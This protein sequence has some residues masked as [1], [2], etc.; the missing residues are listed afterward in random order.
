MLLCTLGCMY[1]FKL[2]FLLFGYLPC[3]ELLGHMV[4]LFLVFEK[5]PYCFPQWLHQ[6]TFPP[7]VHQWIN[8]SLLL[9]FCNL[10]MICCEVVFLFACLGVY[11][12]LCSLNFLNL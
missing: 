8:F 1:L 11:L 12:A 9:I 6:F 4:A 5:P 2:V 10:K 7:T 3:R